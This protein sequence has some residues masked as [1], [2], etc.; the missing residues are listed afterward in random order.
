MRYIL[1][2]IVILHIGFER[3]IYLSLA[4]YLVFATDM[5]TFPEKASEQDS[6]DFKWGCKLGKGGVNKDVQ[7]YKSFTF[8]GVEYCLN[9]CVYLWRDEPCELDIGKLVKVWET[10]SHKRKVKT[11]WF[12]RPN[13][14]T[15]WLGNV[16]PLENELFL[17]SGEGVGVFNINPLVIGFFIF[18]L[19]R[20]SL[21]FCLSLERVFNSVI[22]TICNVL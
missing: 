3:E 19:L 12:F 10:A 13:D 5:S 18:S 8:D 1:L 16:K 20:T 15:H 21:F 22:Q 9:D 14:I 2:V 7:F 11:V 6:P 17:A 4:C